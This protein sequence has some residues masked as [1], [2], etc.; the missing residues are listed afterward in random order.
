[1]MVQSTQVDSRAAARDGD[2]CTMWDGDGTATG[3]RW[4]LRAGH[5]RGVAGASRQLIRGGGPGPPSRDEI[6]TAHAGFA[7]PADL[8]ELEARAFGVRALGPLVLTAVVRRG[9]LHRR[10]ADPGMPRATRWETTSPRSPR[11]PAD[12]VKNDRRRI[13]PLPRWFSRR[14]QRRHRAPGSLRTATAVGRR[15]AARARGVCRRSGAVGSART[16]ADD[17]RGISARAAVPLV[18]RRDGRPLHGDAR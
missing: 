17:G 9:R 14:S 10:G 2:D 7:Y 4:E 6:L 11:P 5:R 12:Y 15:G 8:G 18:R 13:A 16:T 1:M 3:R